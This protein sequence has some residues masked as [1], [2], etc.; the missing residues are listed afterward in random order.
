MDRDGT[1]I[2][3]ANYVRDPDDVVLLPGAAEAVRLLNEHGV[4]TIIVTNQSGIARGYLDAEDYEKVRR[5]VDDLL[6][7][8]GARVDATYM[9]PHLP[10]I[11]GPCECRKPGLGMYRRAISDHAIDGAR[12]LFVGDRWRDVAPAAAFGGLGILL[13]VDSTPPADLAKT[14]DAGIP[15]A[16][17]LAEAVQRYIDALPPHERR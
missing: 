8:D 3:D 7:A 11:T 5:R 16:R 4:A 2:R 14:H 9:C 17:S 6:A 15:T 1:I 12:S 13:D 10:E